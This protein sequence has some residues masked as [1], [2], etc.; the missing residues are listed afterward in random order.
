MCTGA[1]SLG[2][3]QPGREA[4]HSPSSSAEVKNG[5]AIP[6]LFHTSSWRGAE[7]SRGTTSPLF[8]VLN[9]SSDYIALK[10]VI[11]NEHSTLRM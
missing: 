4:D 2:V 1:L 6:P 10:G 8:K 11:I 7:L 3:K 5:E 9:S